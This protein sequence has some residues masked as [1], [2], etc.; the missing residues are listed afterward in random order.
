MKEEKLI[1]Y[2][3]SSK[4]KRKSASES[5]DDKQKYDTRLLAFLS[6]DKVSICFTGFYRLVC[7]YMTDDLGS[8]NLGRTRLKRVI[9]LI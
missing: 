2:L 6:S 1:Q 3:F 8:T 9:K 4:K 7:L 5:M